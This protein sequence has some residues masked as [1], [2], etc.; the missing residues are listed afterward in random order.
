MCVDQVLTK[1]PVARTLING[2]RLLC[3]DM[4]TQMDP[5]TNINEVIHEHNWADLLTS[6]VREA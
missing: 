1:D 5:S 6:R 4:R 3:H 2:K